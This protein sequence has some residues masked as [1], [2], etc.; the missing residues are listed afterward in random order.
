M[1]LG[2]FGGLLE[3]L[4]LYIIPWG[5]KELANGSLGINLKDD[6][7]FASLILVCLILLSG[8]GAYIRIYTFLTAGVYAV[9]DLRL[10]T[11]RS[12]LK[13]DVSFFDQARTAGLLSRL[14][15]DTQLVQVVVSFH[16]PDMLSNAIHLSVGLVFMALIS[17][18]LTLVFL[19]IAPLIMYATKRLT[20]RSQELSRNMQED[21]ANA[22][23]IA[24]RAI[25]LVRVV[26]I[27]CTTLYENAK[28]YAALQKY[29]D[30][31]RVR[32]RRFA[33]L[34][35]IIGSFCW[36]TLAILFWVGSILREAGG[37]SFGDLSAVLMYCLLVSMSLLKISM[38]SENLMRLFGAT[39]RIL[40]IIHTTPRVVSPENA[41]NLSDHDDI[42]VRFEN[43]SF[44]Y[45]ARRDILVLDNISFDIAPGTTTALVGPSGGGKSTIARLIPR[46][47][48]P[49]SGEVRINGVDLSQLDINN[50]RQ[51]IAVVP[52]NTE[53]FPGSIRANIE[54]GLLG[55]L[56]AQ[57]CRQTDAARFEDSYTDF[58]NL[59]V[60]E[61]MVV[62]AAKEANIHE[63]IMSL[64][65]GYETFV[66]D[67]G[68]QLSGGQQQRL[69]FARAILKEP[70][71]LILDEP[72]SALDSE[73]EHQIQKALQNLQ[74]KL[75][76]III[77]HR[78]STVK[79]AD[80]V[81][82]IE[83]GRLVQEGSHSELVKSDG[84]Y[85]TLLNNQ[86]YSTNSVDS[87]SI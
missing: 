60:D 71:L 65:N 77:A 70:K 63:F 8:L 21:L 86:I 45:P 37:L 17:W 62:R 28:Y 54:Y 50:F 35:S 66:G 57:Q 3:A 44:S 40:Q 25:S 55:K 82:V 56:L 27:F 14:S 6:L 5:I 38:K 73:N 49:D 39:E 12:I 53:L 4:T 51:E 74:S 22:N 15:S 85:K 79:N 61:S 58:L 32:E 64:P 84:L 87:P 83:N 11:Y 59:H 16:A 42:A 47:Y 20:E 19:L 41:V 18:K 34:N 43:V 29:L 33:L 76:I 24:D 72:T 13:Q 26:K 78:L 1:L 52:Q 31:A 46:L 81:L 7:T 23:V 30:T 75:T 2:V 68:V 69:V 36:I 48:D 80:K 67:R 9:N 10:K